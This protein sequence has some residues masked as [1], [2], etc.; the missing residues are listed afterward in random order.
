MAAGAI[1]HR[2]FKAVISFGRIVQSGLAR[3]KEQENL[4][5]PQNLAINNF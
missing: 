4:A 2:Q 5:N 1:L 3:Q